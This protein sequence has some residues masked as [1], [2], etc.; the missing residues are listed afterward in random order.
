[1]TVREHVCRFPFTVMSVPASD[2]YLIEVA[3]RGGLTYSAAELKNREWA[4]ELTLGD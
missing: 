4:V 2:F 1:M 3:H